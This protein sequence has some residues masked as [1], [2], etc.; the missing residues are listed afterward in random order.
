MELRPVRR[1]LQPAEIRALCFMALDV[2]FTRSPDRF[3][4]KWEL[5][6]PATAWITVIVIAGSGFV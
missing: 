3:R 5:G 1:G 4:D 2:W 6:E